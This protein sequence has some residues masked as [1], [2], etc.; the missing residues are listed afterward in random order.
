M[1][2]YAEPGDAYIMSNDD[3]TEDGDLFVADTER[4]V[5]VGRIKGDTGN[6]GAAGKN[7]YVHIKFA[8]SLTAND[9]T[10]NNGETPGEYIGI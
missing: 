3:S 1:T 10:A 5:N 2:K 8:N 6:P 7:A 4:W 9:W